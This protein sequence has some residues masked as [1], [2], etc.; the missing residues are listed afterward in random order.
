MGAPA[1]IH[2][3][4]VDEVPLPTTNRVRPWREGYKGKVDES[5]GKALLLLKDMKH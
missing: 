2:S 4:I 5:V 3:F 1:Y